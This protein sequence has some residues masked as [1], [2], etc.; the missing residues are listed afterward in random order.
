MLARLCFAASLLAL[1]CGGADGTPFADDLPQAGQAS[2][3]AQAAGTGGE[4]AVAGGTSAAG[5]SQAGAGGSAMATGGQVGS[6]GQA[7]A[8]GGTASGGASS[9][10]ADGEASGGKPVGGSG[11]MAAGGAGA[12]SGG[13]AGA[14]GQTGDMLDPVP[15]PG[16]PGYVKVFVPHG[17]CVWLH[18]TFKH[19]NEACNVIDPPSDT[20]STASA[21]SADTATIVSSS[22]EIDRFDFDQT[23]CPK[24]CN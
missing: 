24:Q 4:S 13:H 11:G 17:T 8:Q 12:S 15:L 18:G 19:Q 7:A 2:V 16:C 5:A 6:A 20:C 23:G 21:V 10:G 22:A 1:G 9:A 14:G 3:V